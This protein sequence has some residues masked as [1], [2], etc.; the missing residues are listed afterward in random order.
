MTK[1]GHY[2][3]QTKGDSEHTTIHLK[4][5]EPSTGSTSRESQLHETC[6]RLGA[7]MN[8]LEEKIAN[9]RIPAEH[10]ARAANQYCQ[11]SQNYLDHI[12]QLNA[13]VA[14]GL[15]GHLQNSQAN[16]NN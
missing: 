10:Q 6:Q 9:K 13:E 14:K 12:E 16:S 7:T 5:D 1:A 2:T 15:Q 4:L 11:L 8:D 3:V